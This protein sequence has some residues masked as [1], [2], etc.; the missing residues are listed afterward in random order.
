MYLSRIFKVREGKL[1]K[2]TEWFTLLR[3]TRSKEAVATF[4][5]EGVSRE[6]WALFKGIDGN[7]YVIGLNE[8]EGIPQKGDLSIQINQ[9]HRA[10]KEECLEPISDPGKVL[11]DL[12]L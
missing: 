1:D 3:T 10:M 8:A 9:E 11:M 6:V 5:C 7:H 12:R 4:E 2:I